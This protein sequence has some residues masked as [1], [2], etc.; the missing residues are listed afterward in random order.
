MC[1]YLPLQPASLPPSLPPAAWLQRF[2]REEEK[3]DDGDDGDDDDDHWKVFEIVAFA[4]MDVWR[5]PRG[6]MMNV[7]PPVF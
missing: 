3:E 7:V 2:A 5:F 1:M 4:N 6:Y